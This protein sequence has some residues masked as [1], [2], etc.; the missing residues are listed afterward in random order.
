[1][2][3]NIDHLLTK[4]AAYA[5]EKGIGEET[6]LGH[7]IAPDMFPLSR[8]IQIASDNAKAALA[9]LCGIEA[10]VFEDTEATVEELHERIAKTLAF[11]KTVAPSQFEDAAAREVHI[12]YYPGTHFDGHT[13]LVQFALP[14]FFFH[15]TATYALLRAM[16]APIGKSDFLGPLSL[17]PNKE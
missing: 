5:Q 2:L 16:G 12:K 1:M 17:V 4:G 13:Y 7:R 15:A 14:N 6:M 11:L 3:E 9:R 8:Q 10:P